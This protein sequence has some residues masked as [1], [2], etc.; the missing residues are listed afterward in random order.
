MSNFLD[1]WARNDLGVFNKLD[2]SQVS[3]A[4]YKLILHRPFESVILKGQIKFT[5]KSHLGT[6]I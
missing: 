5:C 2:I 3:A 1:T 6:S 4:E